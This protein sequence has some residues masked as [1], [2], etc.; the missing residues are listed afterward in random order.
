MSLNTV[1]AAG[2]VL[3]AAHMNGIQ[4]AWDSY[5]P[6]WTAITTNPA[7]GNGTIT[8]RYLRIG[9]T[10]MFQIV[11]TMGSTTTY[12]TGGWT[13][14][15]PVAAAS[16]GRRV[17]AALDMATANSYSGVGIVLSGG[18]LLFASSPG[19]VAGGPDRS[20]GTGVPVAWASGNTL[21]ATGAYEAA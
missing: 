12:G 9:K 18:S 19:T 3:T 4:A 2:N 20:V 11:L 16:T 6:T 13:F 14:S 17:I 5:T 21:A 15:L 7:L 1:F 10:V 8:G